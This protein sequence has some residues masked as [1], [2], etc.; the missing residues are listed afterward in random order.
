MAEI[1]GERLQRGAG[2]LLEMIDMF[3]ILIVRMVSWA[4]LY[5]KIYEIRHVKHVIYY[6][7]VVP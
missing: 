4:C 7:P 3:T 1:V 2:K 5:V 6:M